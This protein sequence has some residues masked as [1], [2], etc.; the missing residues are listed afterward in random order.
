MPTNQ[1][2]LNGNSEGSIYRGQDGNAYQIVKGQSVQVPNDKLRIEGFNPLP[3]T[4]TVDNIT[5]HRDGDRK[6]F[7]RSKR[8]VC[9]D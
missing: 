9:S 5:F 3:D 2:P 8:A 1:T 7:H 6:L 4:I